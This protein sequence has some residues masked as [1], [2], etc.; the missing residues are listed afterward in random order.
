MTDGVPAQ[1]QPAPRAVTGNELLKIEALPPVA[2]RPLP[3][4]RFIGCGY[5]ASRRMA[6]DRCPMC[7]GSTW[8]HAE[9]KWIADLDSLRRERLDDN[10]RGL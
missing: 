10:R 2:A 6:P 4:F 1:E 7:G 9:P 5:G 8:E 3:Q